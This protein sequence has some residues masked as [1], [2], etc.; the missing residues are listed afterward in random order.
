MSNPLI[1]QGT[2]TGR[3]REV[4]LGQTCFSVFLRGEGLGQNLAGT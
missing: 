2:G 3:G 1:R 4:A